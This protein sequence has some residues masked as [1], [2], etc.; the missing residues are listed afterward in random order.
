MSMT[1]IMRIEL[2]LAK[3]HSVCPNE[4]Y[5]QTFEYNTNLKNLPNTS[6]PYSIYEI[7]LIVK[8]RV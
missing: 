8:L 3:S 6:H 5:A 2:N 1:E 4:Y 7:L